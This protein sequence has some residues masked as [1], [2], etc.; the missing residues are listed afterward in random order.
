[1]GSEVRV[2]A[3]GQV[4]WVRASGV[5]STWATASAPASGIF[6]FCDSLTYTSAADVTVISD[7]GV[8]N[9]NKTTNKQPISVSLTT[10]WTGAHP[11]GVSGSGHTTPMVH[12]EYK[13]TA[14]EAGAAEF[15]LFMGI[16]LNNYQWSEAADG[17]TMQYTFQALAMIG[18]TASGYIKS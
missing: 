12:L 13:G 3:E 15:L 5:G 11:T 14:A 7:R 9:H 10:K 1:M 2:Q 17:N 8:P 18:P 4:W 6:A 16:P